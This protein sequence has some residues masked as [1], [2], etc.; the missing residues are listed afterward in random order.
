M[1]NEVSSPITVVK[2]EAVTVADLIT[3]LKSLDP[4]TRFDP[5]LRL[6]LIEHLGAKLA[7]FTEIKP[8]L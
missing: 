2:G 1:S 7:S 3:Q 6:V 4:K 5:Y 8:V